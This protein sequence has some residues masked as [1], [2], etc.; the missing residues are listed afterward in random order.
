MKKLLLL[1]LGSAILATSAQQA[2]TKSAAKP[3]QTNAVFN[4]TLWGSNSITGDAYVQAYNTSTGQTYYMTIYSNNST[5]ISVPPGNYNISVNTGS[6]FCNMYVS[7]L[8]SYAAYNKYYY[9]FNGINVTTSPSTVV[10]VTY[11]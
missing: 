5:S 9:T 10:S 4:A 2:P 1:L 8:S 7:N 11:N 6:I 3:A